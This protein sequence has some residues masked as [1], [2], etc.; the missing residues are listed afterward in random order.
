MCV[1]PRGAVVVVA[2]AAAAA[3]WLDLAWLGLPPRLHRRRHHCL[4]ATPRCLP[5]WFTFLTVARA[6]GDSRAS[7]RQCAVVPCVAPFLRAV[8]REFSY[9]VVGQLSNVCDRPIRLST[10]DPDCSGLFDAATDTHPDTPIILTRLSL[11][12]VFSPTSPADRYDRRSFSFFLPCFPLSVSFV[13]ICK[14]EVRRRKKVIEKD[15][16]IF[17]SGRMR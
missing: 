15:R 1:P 14:R 12:Q 5:G 7:S 13:S 8:R 2:A 11:C 9:R 6:S 17:Q 3:A 4:P 16:T 10:L